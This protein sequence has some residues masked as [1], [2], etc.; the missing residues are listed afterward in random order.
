MH[1][2][3]SQPMFLGSSRNTQRP[4]RRKRYFGEK[5]CVTSL[6]TAAKESTNW[7]APTIWS[8]KR[9]FRFF[10]VNGK[11]KSY[12]NR[13]SVYTSKPV[14]VSNRFSN[15]VIPTQNFVKSRYPEGYIWHPTSQAYFQSRNSSRFCFQIPNPQ[16]QIREIPGPEKPIKDPHKWSC[17]RIRIKK[18]ADS[19]NRS[20]FV[21]TW[22]KRFSGVNLMKLFQM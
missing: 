16:L 2:L 21:W 9:D 19:K 17:T 10:H 20:A 5:R 1:C 14:W 7:M 15:P 13:S 3:K 6:K 12:T 4:Q 11:C 22:P 18:H 8:S